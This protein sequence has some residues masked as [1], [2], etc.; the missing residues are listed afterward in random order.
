MS[1][2]V[3]ALALVA[4]LAW[5]QALEQA[6]RAFDRGDYAT[7]ARLFEQAHQAT[8]SCETLFFHRA[9]ALPAEPTRTLR[10]S[11]FGPPWSAIPSCFRHI[12]RSPRL[13]PKDATTPKRCGPTSRVLALDPK[14]AAAL[15]RRGEHLSEG[16][17]QRE[18]DRLAG[19]PGRWWRLRI[20]MLTPIS[21]PPTPLRAIASGR[22]SSFEMALLDPAGHASA[23]MGLGNLCLKNGEED[24]AIELLRTAVQAAPEGV[25]TAIPVGLGLQS[26]WAL[27]DAARPIGSRCE[28]GRQRIGSLLPSGARVWRTWPPGG[29]RAGPRAIRGD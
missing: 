18:S 3:L 12:W 5:C 1:L 10:S 28:A 27:P 4:S 7:A 8:P 26:V 14:N 24:R 16:Q 22:R 9:R 13:T 15:E 20:P 23:L 29:S 21:A 6:K 25:R 2:R 11:L 17:C 19:A